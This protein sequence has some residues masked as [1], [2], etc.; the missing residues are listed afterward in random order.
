MRPF[1]L[2]IAT[3]ASDAVAAIAQGSTTP[4]SNDQPVTAREAFFLAGGTTVIDLMKLDVMRPARLIDV[5]RLTEGGANQITSA[6]GGL[7]LGAAVKMADAADHPDIKTNYPVIAETLALA[8]S[9]QL[10]N[11][12]TLGGN[13]LQRTRCTYYRDTTYAQC[14]KRDP[15]SGCAALGGV[16]R[17]HAVL[18]ASDAC[19]ATYPGDF[20][21]ALIALDATVEIA[22]AGGP[23]TIPFASLHA[24]PGD[25]PYIETVLAAG[26]LITAFTIPATPFARRSR[27]VKVR[28][29][30]SY[31]FALASAAIALDLDPANKTV[32]EVR[33]AL[34]GVAAKPW[35]AHEAEAE[36][37]GKI[38]DEASAGRAADAAF[39]AA[40][41]RGGNNYKIPLGKATLIRALLETNA[42]E[43]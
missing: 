40:K 39:S 22:G 37:K 31:E 10:R 14:N 8:A 29:R 12:A 32:R 11:M 23:K 16:N 21:A 3:K 28:D 33:I 1:S 15:G 25:K 4:Q 6:N 18:G 13:V 5:S 42:M 20:A 34:G 26:D 17:P 19:I 30:E 9:A 43:V 41:G 35:R 24:G 7:R 2:T 36:L 27:Y 38:L